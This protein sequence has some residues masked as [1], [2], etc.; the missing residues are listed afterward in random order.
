MIIM[1]RCDPM[2]VAAVLAPF[3]TV[4]G[5]RVAEVAMAGHGSQQRLRDALAAWPLPPTPVVVGGA[6]APGVAAFVPVRVFSLL[7]IPQFHFVAFT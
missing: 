7:F 3:S 6:V 1:I 5:I 4:C 2:I